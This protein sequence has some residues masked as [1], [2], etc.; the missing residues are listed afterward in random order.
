MHS[1]VLISARDC[2]KISRGYLH[3]Q[4]QFSSRN[5][6]H[7]KTFCML[8]SLAWMNGEKPCFAQV[9]RLWLSRFRL[10][11]S[12]LAHLML[13]SHCIFPWFDVYQTGV[14][15][16]SSFYKVHIM[17]GILL[18]MLKQASSHSSLEHLRSESTAWESSTF[19]WLNIGKVLGGGTLL[20][21]FI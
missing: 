4:N 13:P 6:Q 14:L 1:T 9:S 12:Q 2:S 7:R 11:S 16:W 5:L 3:H 17:Q 21:C 8:E 15:S 10:S 20:K 19:F 18:R